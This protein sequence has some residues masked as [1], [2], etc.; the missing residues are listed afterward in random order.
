MPIE[1]G[2]HR[3]AGRQSSRGSTGRVIRRRRQLSQQGRLPFFIIHV[4][5]RAI[6]GSIQQG[7]GS[8]RWRRSLAQVVGW[9]IKTAAVNA[10][11]SR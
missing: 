10:A 2:Q 5:G 3:T 1:I 6:I 8:L 11:R 7:I 9:L 4:I